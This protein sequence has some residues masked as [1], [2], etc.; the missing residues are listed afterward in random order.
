M[1]ANGEQPV[2][3]GEAELR[4]YA[5]VAAL[6]VGEAREIFV[7][8]LGAAPA[9][10]KSRGDFATAAD[11]E[12]EALLR[13]RLGEAT[14]IDVYGEEHGG[15]L[16]PQACWV[17]DP[18][19]G[20]SNYSAGNPNCAI[21]ISLLVGGQ[22][23]VA[24]TDMPLLG[25][26]VSATAG[27]PLLCNGEPLPSLDSTDAAAAPQ[28][29][30]GS[31]G[32]DDRVQFPTEQRLGLIGELADSALRPRISGSIGVDLAFAALGI[33]QAAI[34]FSPH[35]WDNAAGVLLGRCAG[36]TVT[37]AQGNPW[38]VDGVGAIVGAPPAH[39]SVA[40]TMKR[41]QLARPEG[42]QWQ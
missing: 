41:I 28:V 35:V 12:I 9:L 21:L 6:A 3:V 7:S 32:S 30:V 11:L 4:R 39:Q 22:P 1:S 29:G 40:D 8:R 14:G 37:D 24:L 36:A 17:V 2:P 15:R 26:C 38:T 19:D 13:Q 42:T 25:K 16:N 31:V 27:G 18:I 23:V 20:T 33:Y 10:M 5:E 34:S